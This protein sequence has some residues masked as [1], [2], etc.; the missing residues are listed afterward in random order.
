[1]AYKTTDDDH[2]EAVM[3]QLADSVLGL[4]DEAIVG[5]IGEDG[6]DVD[7]EAER[8]SLVLR[9]ASQLWKLQGQCTER[10]EDLN[11]RR[12]ASSLKR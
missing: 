3:N 12:K 2:S 5:E 4:S 7:Q 6:V 9:R 1:M 10:L 8:T 11:S